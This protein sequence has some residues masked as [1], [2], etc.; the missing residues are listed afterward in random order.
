MNTSGILKS[1]GRSEIGTSLLELMVASAVGLI[2]L[3]AAIQSL[4][5]FK[6]Q[7]SNQQSRLA[8]QQDVRLS[9]E[10]LEQE[11]H[12]TESD[13]LSVM[14]QDEIE[15][16]ANINGLSTTVA[17]AVGTGQTTVPVE[18]GRGWPK[19]KII[20]VC[21][22]DRCDAMLLAR[23]GQRASLT[24]SQPITTAIP[25]GASVT[26]RN[27]VRYYSNKDD[28]GT[29]RFLRQVDGGASVLVGEIRQV[30][31][32]YWTEQGRPANRPGLVRLIT[33]EIGLPG[34]ASVAVRDISLRV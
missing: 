14:G 25:A 16:G 32:F 34:R 7:F 4:S 20:V 18:D 23:D 10:L 12:L 17:L 28:N 19:G 22:S 9:L 13:A 30:R 3:A 11:I 27:T 29:L 1:F 26:V 21:W 6:R 15:F 2:I 33:V 24:V 5:L 31:F 8:Q